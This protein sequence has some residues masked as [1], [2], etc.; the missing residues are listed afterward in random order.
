MIALLSVTLIVGL[1][2]G[3]LFAL[4]WCVHVA[5][6]W[7]HPPPRDSTRPFAPSH[8]KPYHARS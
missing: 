3:S 4:A 5:T 7:H 8:V 1:T 2:L 6:T